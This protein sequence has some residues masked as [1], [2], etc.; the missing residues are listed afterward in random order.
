M[1]IEKVFFLSKI[2]RRL[3]DV[4]KIQLQRGVQDDDVD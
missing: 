2:P 3:D 4:N 1:E